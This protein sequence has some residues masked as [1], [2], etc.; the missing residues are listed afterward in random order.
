VL[1]IEERNAKYIAMSLISETFPVCSEQN[2]ALS[3]FMVEL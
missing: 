3:L 1:E 2:F